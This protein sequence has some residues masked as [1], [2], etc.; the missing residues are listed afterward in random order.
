M[1]NKILKKRNWAK[2]ID[3]NFGENKETLDDKIK[4]EKERYV[5]RNSEVWSAIQRVEVD[6]KEFIKRCEKRINKTY[7][8][9]CGNNPMK[10]INEE[11][12]EGL[13]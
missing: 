7:C 13:L 11:A 9:D 10:I 6:V 2:K 8:K 3:I 1:K 4:L 5:G 12:G